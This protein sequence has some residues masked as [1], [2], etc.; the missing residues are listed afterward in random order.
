MEHFV[1]LEQLQMIEVL[2]VL[3][4]LFACIGTMNAP[5]APVAAPLAWHAALDG[6]A[7]HPYH[8]SMERPTVFESPSVT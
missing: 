3:S 6:A 5:V 2:I 1:T 8:R 4:I 7:R